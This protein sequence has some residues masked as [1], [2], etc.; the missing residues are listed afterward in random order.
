MREL[1]AAG[2]RPGLAV[3]LD[4][5]LV[6]IAD[7]ASGCAIT[8]DTGKVQRRRD[9]LTLGCQ[10]AFTEAKPTDSAGRLL[11]SATNAPGGARGANV[12]GE[13]VSF[14]ITDDSGANRRQEYKPEKRLKC[15]FIL[16]A[17]SVPDR[18]PSIRYQHTLKPFRYRQR[19]GQHGS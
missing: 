10:V 15:C 6:D 11:D 16:D 8:N 1:I 9:V 7:S 19:D 14:R 17:D 5:D 2:K 13:G 3:S 18:L 4:F 12:A